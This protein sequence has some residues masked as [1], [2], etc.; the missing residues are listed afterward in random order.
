MI[1]EHTICV[2]HHLTYERVLDYRVEDTVVLCPDCLADHYGI[3]VPEG[4]D[5]L[6]DAVWDVD[7]YPW[8]PEARPGDPL[9]R[10]GPDWPPSLTE[11]VALQD[12]AARG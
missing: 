1:H 7:R 12:Q 4:A 11:L 9:Y 5:D 8:D 6:A 3:L 2:V 10:P